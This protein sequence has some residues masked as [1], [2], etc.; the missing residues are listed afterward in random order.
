[1]KELKDLKVCIVHDWLIGGGAERVVAELHAMF[2]EAP[3]YTSYATDEWKQ[4]LDGKVVTGYL[5]RV[6]KL[7]KY[8]PVLRALWFSSLNLKGYDLVISSSGAE[9]K[10]IKVPKNALHV[11]YC[12]S[13]THYYWVRYDE[14]IKNPGFGA[15]N[16]L[17]RIG[18]ICLL[19]PMRWWDRRAAKRPHVMIANSTFTQANIEKYYQR[20]AEVIFPPVDVDRFKSANQPTRQYFVTAGR[21]TPYMRKDLA[22]IACSEL[23][24]PLKVIGQGPEH[25]KLTKLAGPSVEFITNVTDEEMPKYFQQARAFLLPGMEDFG[26]AAV[27]AMAAGTPVIA[28]KAGGALD[29]VKPGQTGMFFDEQT[30]EAVTTAVQSFPLE[31]FDNAKIADYAQQ[32]STANFR[33]KMQELLTKA[34]AN[35][36]EDSHDSK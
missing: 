29:Y 2:P 18:L 34:L 31:K 15:F 25:D 33:T 13:P 1:M 3:I 23:K 6:P 27:E 36:S 14:Y 5:Q 16:W 22:V 26:I 35:K 19:G 12:H 28:Y 8:L 11:N 21:Q 32:Y 20:K 17:A 30:A 24:L 7:R 10:G 9:A 4:R